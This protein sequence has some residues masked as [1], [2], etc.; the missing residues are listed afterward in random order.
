MQVVI[1]QEGICAPGEG[2]HQRL[3]DTLKEAVAADRAGFD[4]YALSEQH[5]ANGEAI[6]TAP[7]IIL[8]A[9]AA[10]TENIRLRIASVNLLPYNHPIRV[11]EQI[12]MLDVLSSGRAE[13]GGARSN[14]PYTLDGFGIAAD[15]TRMLR[16]EHLNIIGEAFRRGSVQYNSELYQIPERRI[17]PIDASLRPPPVHLS[18]SGVDSHREAGEIGVG[19]MTGLTIVGY[20]YA[21]ACLAG[22]RDG[23]SRA[24][25][26]MGALTNRT[27]LLSVGVCCDADRARARELTRQNTLRFV[28]VILHFF[29]KLADKSPDYRYFH[30][31]NEI[32]ERKTDLEFLI[33][34]TPYVAAGTPEDLIS[35]ARKL[36][37]MGYDDVIWRIDGL[38]HEHNLATIDLIGKEVLPELHS[39]PE[40]PTSTPASTWQKTA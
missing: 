36:Y 30:R 19:A 13:L 10:L 5:F 35:S 9:V 11:A 33:D 27:A 21:E 22:Y 37:D 40:H 1:I 7:E 32:V 14:N 28:E 17:A 2:W 18:A 8:P 25:P 15:Q 29:L 20:E 38:G 31:L 24:K 26:L 3:R 12:A 4:V 39:W 6:T 34:A 16:G 23:I